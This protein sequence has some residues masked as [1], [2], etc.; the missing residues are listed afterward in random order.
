MELT[1]KIWAR[2]KTYRIPV[3]LMGYT[4]Y[5]TD[6]GAL[7]P[8][9]VMRHFLVGIQETRDRLHALNEEMKRW[10]N[11]IPDG[12][13]RVESIRRMHEDAAQPIKRVADLNEA[14][15]RAKSRTRRESVLVKKNP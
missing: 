8:W 7:V 15:E 6:E 3:E 11:Q 13:E 4:G 2:N 9:P 1:M 5:A 12:E 14:V 10:H